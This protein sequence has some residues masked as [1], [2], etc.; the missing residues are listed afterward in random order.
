MP[1][2]LP[3]A[4]PEHIVAVT[5][6]AVMRGT[7]DATACAA[8]ADVTVDHAARALAASTLLG[9][10]RPEGE[11]FAP[12]GVTTELLAAGSLDQ[13]RQIFRTHLERF[14]PFAYVRM[15]LIQ[16]FDFLEACREAKVRFEL[17]PTPAVVRDVFS[18]WGGYARS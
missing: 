12:A 17:T 1:V 4:A 6:F 16:G 2:D 7:V 11:A 9:L 13:K 10:L 15:R 14:E 18:R 5:E 8:F 3:E